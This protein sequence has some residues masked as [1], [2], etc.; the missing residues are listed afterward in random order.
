[1]VA[2]RGGPGNE[3]SGCARDRGLVASAVAWIVLTDHHFR[4]GALEARV[5]AIEIK[6][7]GYD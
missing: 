6:L 3:S 2:R 5:Q 4:L 7:S 1:V